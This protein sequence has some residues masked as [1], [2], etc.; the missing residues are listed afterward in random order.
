MFASAFLS[1]CTFFLSLMEPFPRTMILQPVSAS[2]CLAVSPRGPR[3][4]PT[5]LNYIK[6]AKNKQAWRKTRHI[7]HHT[8]TVF[9]TVCVCYLQHACCERVCEVL[10]FVHL[11]CGCITKRDKNSSLYGCWLVLVAWQDTA[12][13]LTLSVTKTEW[14]TRQLPLC[15]CVGLCVFLCHRPSLSIMH[16]LS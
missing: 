3:I 10:R 16:C 13:L 12:V 14:L 9:F 2:S 6:R 5:K 4:L 1:V 15:V 7:L 11:W 8:H